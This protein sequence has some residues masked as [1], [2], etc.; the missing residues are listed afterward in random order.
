MDGLRRD[1]PSVIGAT[2]SE[3][4]ID[5]D[6]DGVFLTKLNLDETGG[7]GRQARALAGLTT[8]GLRSDLV[9]M[10]GVLGCR[11]GISPSFFSEKLGL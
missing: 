7:S 2:L 3:P 4:S 6:G 9:F 11:V 10:G 5:R 1:F 8:G